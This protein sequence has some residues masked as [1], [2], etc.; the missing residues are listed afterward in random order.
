MGHVRSVGGPAVA[1]FDCG[2]VIC[3]LLSDGWR[4]TTPK[5]VDFWRATLAR[6]GQIRNSQYF[7]VKRT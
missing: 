7:D 2:K 5:V 3:R 1:W 4:S 6:H